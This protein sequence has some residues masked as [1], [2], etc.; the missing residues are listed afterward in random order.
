VWVASPAFRRLTISGAL[1]GLAAVR[2]EDDVPPP[3]EVPA[4]G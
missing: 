4:V 3:A 2:K 1:K